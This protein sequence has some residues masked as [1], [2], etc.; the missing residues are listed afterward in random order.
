MAFGIKYLTIL[1]HTGC[2]VFLLC[3][4]HEYIWRSE[5]TYPLIPNPGKRW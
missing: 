4:G 3:I 5:N 2:L 1:G